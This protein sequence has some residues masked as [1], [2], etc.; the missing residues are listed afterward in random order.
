M[1]IDDSQPVDDPSVNS[2]NTDDVETEDVDTQSTQSDDQPSA[3]SQLLAK[4]KAQDRDS[5]SPRP[6]KKGEESR[7]ANPGFMRPEEVRHVAGPVGGLEG[8]RAVALPA[9]LQ[10]LV[11]EISVVMNKAGQQQ[12]QIEMNSNVLK[13]LHIRIERQE[14][15]LAIQFQTD[16]Q[17]VSSLISRNLDSLSQ[18]LSNL[19]E[20]G[21]DIRVTG[22]KEPSKG[23]D[24]K[25]R[26][27]QGGGGRGQGG[28]GGGR[29]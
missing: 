13:G 2:V 8:K 14:G 18:S 7:L 28:Y 22:L 24:Y 21:V 20:N 3:F 15:A 17:Q 23:L 12:V 26:G 19:G 5:A 11:R 10:H 6:E 29:R 27:D 4:K 1:K 16:S 9:D 25:N